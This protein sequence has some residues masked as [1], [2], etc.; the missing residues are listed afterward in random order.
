MISRAQPASRGTS[1][2]ANPTSDSQHVNL[3]LAAVTTW[4]LR[5][6]FGTNWLRAQFIIAA[7]YTC[8]QL[9]LHSSSTTSGKNY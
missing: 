2:S 4:F 1:N 5:L 3:R 9:T 8:I 6:Y 7:M